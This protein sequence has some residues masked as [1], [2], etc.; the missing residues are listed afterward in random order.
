MLE[1]VFLILRA[2]SPGGSGPPVGPCGLALLC[3]LVTR[4]CSIIYNPKDCSPPGSSVHGLL[5][6]R[7]LGWVAISSSRESSRPRDWTCISC[8]SYIAGGF[9]TAEP[10]G[11]L[12]CPLFHF[13]L[14]ATSMEFL[15]FKV[16]F[17]WVWRNFTLLRIFYEFANSS[18][19]FRYSDS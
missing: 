15:P 10:P 9:F 1:L 3:C 13:F 2:Q 18:W 12:L 8:G 5:Q 7:I 14:S 16:P 11:K 4:S 6:A 17:L 19:Y